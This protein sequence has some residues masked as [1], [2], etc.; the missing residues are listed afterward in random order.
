MAMPLFESAH[1]LPT[2]HIYFNAVSI[3]VF[4]TQCPTD[5]VIH[6]RNRITVFLEPVLDL[7]ERSCIRN[8]ERDMVKNRVGRSSDRLAALLQGQ[9]VVC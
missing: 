5:P 6:R 7:L 1:G 2:I 8:L 4:G 3:R 9:I